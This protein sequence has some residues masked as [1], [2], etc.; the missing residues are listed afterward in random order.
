[1]DLIVSFCL[2]EEILEI[3]NQRDIK[4]L[5]IFFASNISKFNFGVKYINRQ[6]MHITKAKC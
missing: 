4:L 3:H 6:F 5:Y 2:K 1:M